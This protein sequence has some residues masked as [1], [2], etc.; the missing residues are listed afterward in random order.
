MSAKEIG[1]NFKKTAE[2][3]KLMEGK[4]TEDKFWNQ[5]ISRNKWTVKINHFKKAIR[6]NFAEIEGTR[7][8]IEKLKNKGYKLGLLSD[9][10]KEWVDYC[11]K[12]FDYHKLFHSTQYSFEVE[13]CKTDKKAFK[14]ILK[15]LGE[16]P[17][18]CLFIDDNEKNIKVAKS[19]GLN[20][21]QFKNS[22]Q[23]KK[24]LKTFAINL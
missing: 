23:L 9:H 20:R 16:I 15:K 21:I 11:N 3:K 4:I 18:D 10:A 5:I 6:D 1:I 19:M 17:E 22:E 24:E 7:E 13:C 14:L 2:F 12:K 8:I